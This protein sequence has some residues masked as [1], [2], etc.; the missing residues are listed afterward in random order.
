[1]WVVV[2]KR[3]TQSSP[4]SEGS[5]SELSHFFNCYSSPYMF[6]SDPKNTRP[7]DLNSDGTEASLAPLTHTTQG[8]IRMDMHGPYGPSMH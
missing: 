6:R 4:E 3:R 5:E 8:C 7:T 2:C 1:M